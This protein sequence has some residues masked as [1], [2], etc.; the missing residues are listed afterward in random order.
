MKFSPGIKETNLDVPQGSKLG[1]ILYSTF[2][3]DIMIKPATSSTMYLSVDNMVENM[4]NIVYE[5]DNIIATKKLFKIDVN[6]VQTFVKVI[7]LL[8]I[9]I[10]DLNV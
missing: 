3:N 1:P 9:N 2:I 5:I 7:T 10:N 8:F 4:I 6:K